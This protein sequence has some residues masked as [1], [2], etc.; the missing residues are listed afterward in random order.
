MLIKEHS[1]PFVSPNHS[2]TEEQFATPGAQKLVSS[3][4]IS[5]PPERDEQG[6]TPQR[7]GLAGEKGW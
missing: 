5:G 1:T 2:N 4:V 3:V 6:E 7:K